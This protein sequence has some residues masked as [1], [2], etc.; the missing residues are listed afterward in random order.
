MYSIIPGFIAQCILS[1]GKSLLSVASCC[2][3]NG[4]VIATNVLYVLKQL[5][6]ISGANAWRNNGLLICFGA[7]SDY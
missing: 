4:L 7:I 3:Q 2:L 6:L 5:P 1:P